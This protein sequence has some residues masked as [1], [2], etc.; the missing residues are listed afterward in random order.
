MLKK[1]D[2][3]NKAKSFNCYRYNSMVEKT[4]EL[5]YLLNDIISTSKYAVSYNAFGDRDDFNSNSICSTANKAMIQLDGII[6]QLENADTIEI[7]NDEN[8]G[9]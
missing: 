8:K 3:A 4:K 1:L 6:Y 7:N 2:D 5:K 9:E